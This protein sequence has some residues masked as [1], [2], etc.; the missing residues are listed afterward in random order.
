MEI[1]YAKTVATDF[2]WEALRM[3]ATH[4]ESLE[5]MQKRKNRGESA[6]V[7]GP[8]NTSNY[9]TRNWQL[10]DKRAVV[11]DFLKRESWLHGA[12]AWRLVING[13]RKLY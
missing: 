2:T 10:P 1:T 6:G 12:D 3:H 13:Y 8:Y 7:A 9:N 4:T 5:F 11:G